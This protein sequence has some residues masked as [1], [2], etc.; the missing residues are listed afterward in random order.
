VPCSSRFRLANFWVLHP[1]LEQAT[2]SW[3]FWSTPIWTRQGPHVESVFYQCRERKGPSRVRAASGELCLLKKARL[4]RCTLALLLVFITHL[5]LQ[6]YALKENMA[7][8]ASQILERIATAGK[9]YES[10]EL[11][12]R[13][14]LIELGRDLVASLEI[15]SEFLQRSFW[16]EVSDKR[17]LLNH[18][19]VLTASSLRCQRTA[20]SQSKSSSSNISEMPGNKAV[21]PM[22]LPRRPV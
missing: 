20:S 5:H 3:P 17:Q 22:S 16:A 14:L 11:G 13:E 7:L 4:A 19:T 1:M 10:D 9:A 8:P 2:R 6:N 18:Q 15:P 21:L 12:S